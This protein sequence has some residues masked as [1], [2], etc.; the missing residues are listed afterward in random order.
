MAYRLR[1]C[2]RWSAMGLGVW[3][4][5]LLRFRDERYTCSRSV[6][7]RE[8]TCRNFSNS[9]F[10]PHLLFLFGVPHQFK[11]LYTPLTDG[12]PCPSV[13]R[14]LEKHQ[15]TCQVSAYTMDL[16]KRQWENAK[17]LGSMMPL[18]PDV[19]FSEGKRKRDI[20]RDTCEIMFEK[21]NRGVENVA[22]RA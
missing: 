17:S 14:L 3:W 21:Q 15:E 5:L 13:W 6:L 10:Q 20:K 16:L 7:H 4:V 18:R 11:T 9:P 2:G 19:T 8:G 22:I 1:N 12:R